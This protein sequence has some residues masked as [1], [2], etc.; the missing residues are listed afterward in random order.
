[1]PLVGFWQWR[2]DTPEQRPG[3]HVHRYVLPLRQ[4]V[5]ASF[6]PLPRSLVQSR[7][8]RR[9]VGQ[10]VRVARKGGAGERRLMATVDAKC[11]R[12]I[13]VVVR[14]NCLFGV[15]PRI[16]RPFC[17]RQKVRSKWASRGRRPV[18]HLGQV[19]RGQSVNL[20]NH[21]VVNSGSADRATVQAMEGMQLAGPAGGTAQM[22]R[23][24]CRLL[25]SQ[26]NRQSDTADTDR[27]H[28]HS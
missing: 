24:F 16:G 19:V 10:Q 1:M 22:E 7:S 25:R 2:H 8:L 12:R 26:L 28:R 5:L 14:F 20:P 18:C 9:Y 23:T 13:V 4:I 11:F 6:E 17:A 21:Y 3:R 15:E 27:F